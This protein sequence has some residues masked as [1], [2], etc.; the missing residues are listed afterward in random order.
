[1]DHPYYCILRHWRL[2]RLLFFFQCHLL[3]FSL[4]IDSTDVMRSLNVIEIII[5]LGQWRKDLDFHIINLKAVKFRIASNVVFMEQWRCIF[6]FEIII[7]IKNYN[8][9]GCECIY[10]R[11]SASQECNI[12]NWLKQQLNLVSGLLEKLLV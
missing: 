9:R 11:T 3:N 4:R 1:M 2:V 12:S 8:K 7:D 5:D 10:A 6:P